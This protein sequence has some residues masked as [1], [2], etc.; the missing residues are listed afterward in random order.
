METGDA[1]NL[2]YN[3]FHPDNLGYLVLPPDGEESSS[4]GMCGPSSVEAQADPN[5]LELSNDLGDFDDIPDVPDE[6]GEGPAD[7]D[8]PFFDLFP[9][10]DPSTATPTAPPNA[11]TTSEAVVLGVSNSRQIYTFFLTSH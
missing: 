3:A 10:T 8:Y 7:S 4:S 5:D 2:G 1:I 11:N 6:N 9:S